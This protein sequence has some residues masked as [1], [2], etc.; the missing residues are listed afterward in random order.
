M[1][2]RVGVSSALGLA[3]MLAASLASLVGC[4]RKPA[5]GEPVADASPIRTPALPKEA[6]ADAAHGKELVLAYECN[7]CH[8]GA[9]HAAAPRGKHCVQCHADILADRFDAPPATIARWKP[10]VKE[11]A[12]AP[13]LE[14][15]GKRLSRKWV[16][17]YLLQPTDLRPD[18]VQSMPR[19]AMSSADARDLAAYLVPEDDGAGAVDLAGA[20]LG[21]G[22]ALL[23]AKGCGSC[24]AFSGV[25]SVQ[26]SPPPPMDG[27]AFERAR[28][29]APDL[30]FTRDRMSAS[31]LVAWLR[32]PKGV[33]PDTPMPKIA[34]TEP[35]VKDLAGYLMSA[36]LAAAP[37]PKTFERLPVLTRR[38]TFKEVDEK[39]FHRTCWHCHSEPDYAIGDGGPGNSGGFGFKPR[40]LN[41]SD[42]GGI[43]AGF[44]DDKG[45]RTSV[46]TKDPEGLPRL[47][48]ALV[49][50][51]DEEGGIMGPV[52]GMP[53]GYPSLSAEDI[54]L[55]ETWIAQGRPR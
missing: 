11:L 3:V 40:G 5:G 1:S 49:A 55:V 26:N 43:A 52:R 34:L 31:K 12:L 7:R 15:T 8:D 13:S 17:Q 47:V 4:H 33:K 21:K 9:G 42:Y 39:V 44:L 50:R 32:D 6:V 38:V 30:R 51:H 53:L 28:T 22:R 29:L 16:E 45:E 20:D 14:A 23:D 2:F 35:E 46:F 19:L 48:A 18:L 27:K 54:Q 10:R 25:A 36:E 24:H 41:L 37:S